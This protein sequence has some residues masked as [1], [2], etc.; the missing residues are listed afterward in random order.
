[1]LDIVVGVEDIV[2]N[3]DLVFVEFNKLE[4]ILKFKIGDKFFKV[5]VFG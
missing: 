5:F 1:M 3:K 4:Y 2:V